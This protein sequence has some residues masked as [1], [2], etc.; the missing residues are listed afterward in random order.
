MAT[1]HTFQ[2]IPG[3]EPSM[4]F[5]SWENLCIP[6]GGESHHGQGPA[7][8][9]GTGTRRPLCPIPA[10][11]R[12]THVLLPAAP[13]AFTHPWGCLQEGFHSGGSFSP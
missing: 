1:Q 10:S 13:L 11:P 5:T 8:D 12:V 7:E 2:N 6:A 3:V 9:T 4:A